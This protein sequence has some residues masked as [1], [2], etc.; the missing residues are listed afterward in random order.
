[1]HRVVSLNFHAP[2]LR[3]VLI[4]ADIQRVLI[5][6]VA[7]IVTVALGVALGMLAAA[8]NNSVIPLLSLSVAGAVLYVGR[9]RAIV[10]MTVI[11]A[12]LVF[13]SVFYT[14]S[15]KLAGS[16]VV[17]VAILCCGFV[18][19]LQRSL[20]SYQTVARIT[21]R[22]IAVGA[23]VFWFW[24]SGLATVWVHPHSTGDLL[25]AAAN[26]ILLCMTLLILRKSDLMSALT[27]L[28]IVCS[29]IAI[30]QFLSGDPL[31]GVIYP[32]AT[33]AEWAHNNLTIGGTTTLRAH[34]VF[35]GPDYLAPVLAVTTIAALSGLQAKRLRAKWF[36]YTAVGIQL[37]AATLSFSRTYFLA[38]VVGLVVISIGRNWDGHRRRRIAFGLLIPAVLATVIVAGL[39]DMSRIEHSVEAR[40][41]SIPA[42][43]AQGGFSGR[44]ARWAPTLSES[45]HNIVTGSRTPREASSLIS[46]HNLY[47]SVAL[48]QGV[49]AVTALLVIL[50]MA[51]RN[52]YRQGATYYLGML[53][54]LLAAGMFVEIVADPAAAV[55]F[56]VVVGGALSVKR[57]DVPRA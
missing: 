50:Y 52:A 25:Q 22:D 55:V 16:V 45:L 37:V 39:G 33:Y 15:H 24:F 14:M 27:M 43:E 21:T 54:A 3:S 42:E 5:L 56:W 35:V 23:A 11:I 30:A 8:H 46:A 12:P 31:A 51:V 17:T 28:G 53:T 18:Y 26:P 36:A 47:I 9:P 34:S 41:A 32:S 1:M 48:Y 4:P 19:A 7:S 44:T 20:H 10:W 57:V 13:D 29:I 6:V 38:L 49:I 40:L 2:N